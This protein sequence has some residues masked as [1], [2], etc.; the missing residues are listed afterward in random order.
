MSE[1]HMAL[2]RTVWRW[3]FCAGLVVAP[4]LF[5]LAVTGA[6]YLFNDEIND[7]LH[8][9]KRFAV[10]AGPH[11][12]ISKIAASA[13]G[14]HPNG[15]VTR[16]D[17]PTAAGRTYQVYVTPDMGKPVRV[18]IDPA[19]ARVQ[20]EYDYYY[21]LIGIADQLHGSLL[22]GDVGD[23]IV[24][25]AACWGLILLAT[26]LYLWWP[27]G[28][29]ILRAL[30]PNFEASGR[31]FWKSLHGATGAWTALLIA[32]L[33][34]TGLPWAT[35]WGGMFR[36]VTAAAGVGY[37]SSVRTH[38]APASTSLIVRDVAGGAAPWTLEDMPAPQSGHHSGHTAPGASAGSP[39]GERVGLDRVAAIVAERGMTDPYRLVFPA[40]ERG[41]FS[42]YTY[43]DQP[44][45][46]RSIYID[47]YSG[48]VIRDIGFKDYGIAAKAVELGVQLHMGNY[49]GVINQVVM[50]IPCIGIVALSIT[51]PC[52][53][54]LRRPK[55]KLGAPKS[56]APTTLRNL[57]LITAGMAALF[58][59]AAASLV[60]V[61]TID[62]VFLR[63]LAAT[64]RRTE[65]SL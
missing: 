15:K 45:G 60:V 49:F 55:G 39:A 6:I 24:E 22:M 35:V 58:P 23:A 33:I 2:Y 10:S 12:P 56:P 50:L 52:M 48:E 47:Q 1:A 63:F 17:T 27:R 29:G 51:G 18:F 46:Q 54:W 41:V 44:E 14:G 3:H 64:G 25:I 9:D 37:P 65:P 8:S 32:F 20:G 5:I 13:L 34:V 21:T 31:R 53:W 62:A 26:G 42:A 43:P 4:F 7:V 61:W 57:V 28:V 30:V 16:I 38:G 19:S 11:Q 36:K 59:L 40:D